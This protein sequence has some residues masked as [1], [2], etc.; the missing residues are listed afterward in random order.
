MLPVSKAN[1]FSEKKPGF[2]SHSGHKTAAAIVLDFGRGGFG[3]GR[4][5]GDTALRLKWW[6]WWGLEEEEK[7]MDSEVTVKVRVI[8]GGEMIISEILCLFLL[9]KLLILLVPLSFFPLHG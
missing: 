4:G 6:G 3:C 1:S 5:D 2:L 7:L 8:G 9:R